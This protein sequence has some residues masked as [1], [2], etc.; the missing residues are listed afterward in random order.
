MDFAIK[1]RAVGM[2]QR[3]LKYGQLVEM[4]SCQAFDGDPLKGEF[5][6]AKNGDKFIT[7]FNRQ[8]ERKAPK[9]VLRHL[10]LM[11]RLQDPD[12]EQIQQDYERKRGA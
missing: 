11:S 7:L 4:Q 2:K 1:D 6:F 9:A 10:L 5:I 8:Q 3:D 12:S